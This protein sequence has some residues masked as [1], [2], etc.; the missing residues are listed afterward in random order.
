MIYTSHAYGVLEAIDRG[1]IT[2]TFCLQ[3]VLELKRER[4]Y[5]RGE[6]KLHIVANVK[7]TIS[8]YD[9]IV[10]SSSSPCTGRIGGV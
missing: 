8:E 1:E 3:I 7:L 6:L 5:L 2:C 9:H 4:K 10:Y